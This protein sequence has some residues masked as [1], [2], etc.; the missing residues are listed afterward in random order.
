V[1]LRNS[2]QHKQDRMRFRSLW[3]CA[4]AAVRVLFRSFAAFGLFRVFFFGFL[5]IL[6]VY[7]EVRLCVPWVV[8][9]GFFCILEALCVLILV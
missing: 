4:R 3:R 1:F 7:L 8:G 2:T 5:C 6:F 9:L